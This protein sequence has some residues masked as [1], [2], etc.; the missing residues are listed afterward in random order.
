[1]Y[2][3][4]WLACQQIKQRRRINERRYSFSFSQ[5]NEDRGP[6]SYVLWDRVNHHSIN[7]AKT[8]WLKFKRKMHPLNN[9]RSRKVH[10]HCFRS[11][12]FHFH[13]TIWNNFRTY[14][15]VLL[16]LQKSKNS[17]PNRIF[18]RSYSGPFVT[19]HGHTKIAK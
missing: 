2:G 13:T 9:E 17:L 11:K 8:I 12:E 15:A 5:N 14:W 6:V 1:M 3:G 16:I 10:S 4:W 18:L 7:F 19:L